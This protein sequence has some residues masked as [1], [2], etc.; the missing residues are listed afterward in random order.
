MRPSGG[1]PS[2]LQRALFLFAAV[3][4]LTSAAPA[5]ADSFVLSCVLGDTEAVREALANG[6]NPNI[7]DPSG[8]PPL[9]SAVR[10][11]TEA[12]LSMH[13]DVIRLLVSFGADPDASAPSG[14]TPLL[15][16]LR[17]GTPFGELTALLLELGADPNGLSQGVRPL[18]AASREPASALQLELLLAHGADIRLK[19][20][21]GCSPL[22]AA[23]TASSPETEKVRLLLR[24]GAEAN[25]AF[26]LWGD[27]RLSPLMAAAVLGSPE[28]VRLLLDHGALSGLSSRSG[29]R[30]RDYA[31]RAGREDNAA[32]LR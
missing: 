21:R 26:D 9:Y 17:K 15:L 7:P 29:L 24:A 11:G 18:E 1:N 6:A 25:E 8:F 30:A 16:S 13:L 5:G 31:L 14:E 22:I 3:P 20:A 12:P 27:Q 32:L 10:A 23:V 4:L 2:R 28:L 19:D